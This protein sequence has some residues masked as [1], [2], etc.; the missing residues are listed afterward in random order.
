MSASAKAPA[1]LVT[2]KCDCGHKGQARMNH[3]DLC[4]CNNCGATWWALRP[5]RGGPL[6]AVLHPGF[7]NSREVQKWKSV[8]DAGPGQAN[9]IEHSPA[10]ANDD[11]S[12]VS[13]GV[14]GNATRGSWADNQLQEAA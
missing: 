11:G 14:S 12:P 3:Y 4:R 1:Q 10:E 8:A 5:K 6:V 9:R 2:H 13:E 7:P